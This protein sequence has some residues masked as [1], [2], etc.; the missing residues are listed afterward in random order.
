M[1]PHRSNPLQFMVILKSLWPTKRSGF[2]KGVNKGEKKYRR[3]TFSFKLKI[4]IYLFLAVTLLLL[5]G[6]IIQPETIKRIKTFRHLD[7]YL[8][9]QILFFVIILIGFICILLR[10]LKNLQRLKIAFVELFFLLCSLY[11]DC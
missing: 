11:L 6:E 2:A 7:T 8:I 1:R 5:L 10:A 3:N 4:G 9:Y